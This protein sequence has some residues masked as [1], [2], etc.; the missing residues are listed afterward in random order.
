M[1][2]DQRGATMY[3]V[4]VVDVP[5]RPHQ[6]LLCAMNMPADHAVHPTA[7]GRLEHGPIIEVAE[8][9]DRPLHAVFQIGRKRTG[10]IASTVETAAVPVV[11][12]ERHGI[13]LTGLP[14]PRTGE[15]AV[16][17]MT[18]NDQHAA[19]FQSPMNQFVAFRRHPE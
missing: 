16:E 10:A 18:V 8:V 6:A 12:A 9:L 1:I 13:S 14:Q 2:L 7:P 11:D 4:A 17:L 15:R 3:P 19:T 5:D